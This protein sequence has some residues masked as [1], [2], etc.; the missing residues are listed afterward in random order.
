MLIIEG[1][2]Q[3]QIAL[4][5]KAAHIFLLSAAEAEAIAEQQ[6]ISVRDNWDTTCAEAG[7]SEIDKRLLWRRQFLNPYCLESAPVRLR[8]LAQ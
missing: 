6:I 4:C 2:R 7:L 1:R 3:S 5:I 8:A